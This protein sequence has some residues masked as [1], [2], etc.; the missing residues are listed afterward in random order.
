MSAST[1][2]APSSSREQN[3]DA[4]E[5]LVVIGAGFGRTGTSSLRD[6]L[7]ILGFGPC[8]HMREVFKD[9]TG[10][11]KWDTIATKA[12]G[13]R[14]KDDWDDIFHGYRSSVDLPSAT[15][16]DELAGIYPNAKIILTVRDPEK[17]YNS[18]INT[19]A[20]P[21]RIWRLIYKITFLER[22]ASFSRMAENVVWK[23]L[24]CGGSYR[25]HSEK[26]FAMKSF[27]NW[28]QRVRETADPNKLLEFNV[29]DGWEPL[30]DFLG[31]PVPPVPFPHVWK[32][33]NFQEMVRKRR[34]NAVT[35][36]VVATVIGTTATVL[37]VMWRRNNR[38]ASVTR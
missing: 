9:P 6:A 13:S 15:F 24:L 22:S 8:Y 26:E 2:S 11:Q 29:Q 36:L 27:E 21:T 28:N 7:E 25:L 17:W 31:C 19:I 32:R 16:W 35:R 14:T 38:T 33:E 23:P 5:G 3:P 30:C 10:V 1:T 4:A 34:Q 12:K 20:P 37:A 18:V